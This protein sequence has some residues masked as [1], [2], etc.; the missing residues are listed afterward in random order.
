MKHYTGKLAVCH[1]TQPPLQAAQVNTRLQPRRALQ[2]LDASTS[3]RF[4]KLQDT[5]LEQCQ[6]SDDSDLRRLKKHFK[7]LKSTFTLYDL[8]EGFIEGEGCM[9]TD[10]PGVPFTQL[11]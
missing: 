4:L 1:F 11:L 8:K 10:P 9:H 7:T 2:L 5:A 6:D 3:D